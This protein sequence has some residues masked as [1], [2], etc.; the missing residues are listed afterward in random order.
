MLTKSDI[1]YKGNH[2]FP[3]VEG[4]RREDVV[5]GL[6]KPQPNTEI[7]SNRS[8]FDDTAPVRNPHS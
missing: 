2:K 3:F 7:G 5:E 8:G 1:C 6:G 4:E